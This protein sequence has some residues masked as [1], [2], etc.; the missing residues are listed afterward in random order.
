MYVALKSAVLGSV[1]E[2]GRC[3]GLGN[4]LKEKEALICALRNVCGGLAII[5]LFLGWLLTGMV[6]K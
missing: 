2:L 1:G 4:L 6:N 5:P 3:A